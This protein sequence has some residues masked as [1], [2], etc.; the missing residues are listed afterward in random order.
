M[1]GKRLLKRLVTVFV[2]MLCFFLFLHA[3]DAD[4]KTSAVSRQ[5][6]AMSRAPVG[7]AADAPYAT[8]R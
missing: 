7:A 5:L 2:G 8:H 4:A 3:V 1:T 6:S